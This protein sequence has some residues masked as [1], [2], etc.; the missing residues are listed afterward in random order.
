MKSPVWGNVDYP[1]TQAFGE[2]LGGKYDAWYAYAADWGHPAGT[3]IALDIGMPKGTNIY[4]P[5]QPVRIWN[6]IDQL[7]WYWNINW[8]TLLN[9]WYLHIYGVSLFPQPAS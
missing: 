2:R 1:V 9:S 8:E 5:L 7:K 4:A 3:H 6:I